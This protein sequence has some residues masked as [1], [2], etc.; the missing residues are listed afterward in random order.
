MNVTFVSHV[1]D[2][3]VH[4]GS[5]YADSILKINNDRTVFFPHLKPRLVYCDD[6]QDIEEFST[7]RGVVLNQSDSE[8]YA[9]FNTG[10]VPR[11][12]QNEVIILI[13]Y[14]VRSE[15]CRLS[16]TK[17]STVQTC[18]NLSLILAH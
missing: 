4:S 11:S 5:S 10:S 15:R 3:S 9:Q 17:R 1:S 18:V 12:W 6:V 16:Y 8:F 14:I 7:L 2:S 13:N